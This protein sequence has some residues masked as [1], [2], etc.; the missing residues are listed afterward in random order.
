MCL[1][2]TLNLVFPYSAPVGNWWFWKVMTKLLL[3]FNIFAFNQNSESICSEMGCGYGI[4]EV[5]RAP[6]SNY[7]VGSFA[8]SPDDRRNVSI[9]LCSILTPCHLKASYHEK[10]GSY[11]CMY[12]YLWMKVSRIH[13]SRHLINVSSLRNRTLQIQNVLG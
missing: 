8:K 5:G 1:Y 11:I 9:I 13:V 12:I 10:Y 4:A 3:I 6:R 2:A 7:S